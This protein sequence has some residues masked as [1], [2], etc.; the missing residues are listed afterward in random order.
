MYKTKAKVWKNNIYYCWLI[1]TTYHILA[2]QM[3][4]TIVGAF[5]LPVL[6]SPGN[7]FN[8]I[9]QK[10]R[11]SL[12]TS[13]SPL[14]CI[15]VV[16]IA[17]LQQSPAMKEGELGWELLWHS[18]VSYIA[19]GCLC[20]YIH[21]CMCVCNLSLLLNH[22][23]AKKKVTTATTIPISTGMRMAVLSQTTLSL[24]LLTPASSE[25][26]YKLNTGWFPESE[27]SGITLETIRYRGQSSKIS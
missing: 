18:G 17:S 12:P 16:T 6:P 9:E 19:P 25:S 20:A 13:I 1:Y 27:N 26:K 5:L 22:Q 14:W 8:T 21:V 15:S 10:R 4:N 24:E 11:P 23:N 7:S 3:Y 2:S